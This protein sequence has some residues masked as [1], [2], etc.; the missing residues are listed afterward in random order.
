MTKYQFTAANWQTPT[1]GA[2]EPQK[3]FIADDA[4][5]RINAD[6]YRED[7]SEKKRV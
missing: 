3:P 5:E 7:N 1:T 6:F 4:D 2:K